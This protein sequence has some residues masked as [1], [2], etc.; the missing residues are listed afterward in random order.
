MAVSCSACVQRGKESL[1]SQN[2][3]RIDIGGIQEQAA[4]WR[5][6]AA[7]LRGGA[8]HG[9]DRTDG[10]RCSALLSCLL[11]QTGQ[12]RVMS[13]ILPAQ[14]I[15]LGIPAPGANRRP[16]SHGL[17]RQSEARRVG[18]ECVSTFRSRGYPYP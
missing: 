6:W 16:P 4:G 17:D 13:G 12:S 11:D 2:A 7:A 8:E 18:K 14:T 5:I 15:N 10:Q 9:M 3:G 1:F